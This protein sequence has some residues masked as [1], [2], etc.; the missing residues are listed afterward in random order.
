MLV[1]YDDII[2]SLQKSGG[3]SVYWTENIKRNIN[4]VKHYVYDS[5]SSNIFYK[6]ISLP[7]EHVLSSKNLKIDR[8]IPPKYGIKEKYIFHSSYFRY[9]RDDSAINIT[10]VHDCTIEKFHRGFKPWGHKQQLALALR[11]SAGVICVSENTKKDLLKYY[12]D[13]H[14]KIKVILNGYDNKSYFYEPGAI[15]KNT[16]LFVGA[17]TDYKRFDL[18]IRLIG[19]LKNYSLVIVGGGN[20]SDEEKN[21]LNEKAPGRFTKL[22]YIANDQLRKL[23]NSSKFLFY[24]SEYE[25]FGIPLLEA[26]ACGCVVICQRKSSVPEVVNNTAVYFTE[27]KFTDLIM[28]INALENMGQYKEIQKNGLLN[29]KQFSWDKCARETYQFY[30]TIFNC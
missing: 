26:Q 13:F 19:E 29:V 15:R 6:S 17:R 3:G 9:S 10:T 27:D 5:A 28:Q 24:P 18:A 16:I 14:G 8:F 12:P 7:N 20:L 30:E 22:N 21:A 2:Y 1:V 23:Y 4:N 11:H 25:G